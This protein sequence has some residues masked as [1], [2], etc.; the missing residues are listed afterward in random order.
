[1]IYQIFIDGNHVFN[2]AAYNLA[3]LQEI[4]TKMAFLGKKVVLNS[5][6]N[7]YYVYEWKDSEFVLLGF[8]IEPDMVKLSLTQ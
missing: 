5:T 6:F 2:I 8:I 3:Y 1:M 4:F 7:P